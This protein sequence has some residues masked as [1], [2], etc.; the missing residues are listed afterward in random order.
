MRAGELCIRD[1]VTARANETAVD[2]A[3]RMVSLDVGDVIVVEERAG[4]LPRPVGIVTDR[5]LVVHVLAARPERL[6]STTTLADIMHREL[7]TARE[8]DDVQSVLAKMREHVIR[9]IPII[10][11]EGGLQG[12]VS[13]DD[14]LGLLRDD[15]ATATELLEH[16]GQGPL[17]RAKR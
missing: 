3:R 12:V 11:R 17:H 10:D 14:V 9:R 13:I 16:Q 4:R 15:I 6:P 7:V 8:D 2:V 1:V 5:D